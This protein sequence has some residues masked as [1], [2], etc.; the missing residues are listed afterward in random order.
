MRRW[1][2]KSVL[3]YT[4]PTI[5]LI[6]LSLMV[7]ITTLIIFITEFFINVSLHSFNTGTSINLHTYF[8]V[9]IITTITIILVTILESI[10]R[11][12]ERQIK[13]CVLKALC[14]YNY[15]N[16]LGLKENTNMPVIKVSKTDSGYMIRISCPSVDFNKLASLESTIGTSLTKKFKDYSVTNKFEDIAC[17]Y[18]D[19]YV[20]NVIEKFSKQNIYKT[21]DDIPIHNSH[22]LEIRNDVLIDLSKVLNSSCLLV[23]KTRSGKSTG[24][25]STFLLPILLQGKDEYNS[26]VII[27]DP[28]NAELSQCSCVLSPEKNGDVSHI[29]KAIESFNETRIKRQEYLN[30]ETLKNNGE[31]V[32]W[33]ELGM[34]PSILFIDEFIA[35]Q[36]MIPKKAPKDNPLY[37]LEH[38]K[39]LLQSIVTQG[40]SAG[41]F[42]ILSTAEASVES[43]GLSK[44]VNN[45]CGI[46]VLFKPTKAEAS[47]LW[48]SNKLENFREW[49]YS[50]GDTIFS[51]DD[52]FH[53]MVSF[54]KFP[55]L[56]FG[57]Y[58]ALSQALKEYYR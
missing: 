46:K 55:K 50:A 22:T 11:S 38:F 49:Q 33:W 48:D 2:S 34:K 16:P 9:G 1:N 29:L 17:N 20:E 53:N 14:S 30:K 56:E 15:G 4:T 25:I 43:G 21:V 19:Y 44:I 23:G 27:V 13:Y 5:K 8:Y 28:K 7:F 42:L 47:F 26:E 51:I 41:T 6:L 35:F 36:G 24:A 18:V 57:E 10:F 54:V 31:S 52:G 37:C 3:R 40:A 45:A 39:S 58:K 12:D 32:K